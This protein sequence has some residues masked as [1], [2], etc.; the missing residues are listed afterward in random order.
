MQGKESDPKD[1]RISFIL[2]LCVFATF[3]LGCIS[4]YFKW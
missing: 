4:I 2:M 1:L 3:I